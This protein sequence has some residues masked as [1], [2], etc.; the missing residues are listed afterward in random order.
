MSSYATAQ[1][2]AVNFIANASIRITDGKQV[3]FTDFPYLSGA[4]GH[5]IYNYPYFV[6]QNNDVTT[7]ITNRFNDHIDQ[8]KILTLD[9]DIVAPDDVVSDLKSKYQELIVL[10]ETQLAEIKK[11]T[12]IQKLI[13]PNAVIR[14]VILEELIEPSVTVA[15]EEMTIGNAKVTTYDTPTAGSKN[16]SYLID[17]GGKKIYLAGDTGDVEH[18][19]ALPPLDMAFISPWL[20]ENARRANAL[21][22]TKKLIIYQHKEEEIIPNCFTCTIPERGDFIPF[23]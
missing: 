20:F 9:W 18:L 14:P 23:E 8:E 15:K 6:E 10:R 1:E 5:M 19:S 2:I 3:I 13:N 7:L 21:P 17:W 22:D 12:E 16:L 4:F 11:N